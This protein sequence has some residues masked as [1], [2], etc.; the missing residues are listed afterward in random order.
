MFRGQ[1]FF[2]LEQKALAMPGSIQVS[3]KETPQGVRAPAIMAVLD[4]VITQGGAAVA[5]AGEQLHRIF[6]NIQLG[7]KILSTGQHFRILS[8]HVRGLQ[9]SQ[10]ADVPATN[11]GVFN[12]RV[13]VMIPF[14]D[15]RAAS[16]GDSAMRPELFAQKPLSIDFS[17][18][19]SLFPNVASITGT[20]TTYLVN[21]P[22]SP[23]VLPSDVEI[24]KLDWNGQH[25]VIEGS[26]LYT[27][28][29]IFNEDG[30]SIDDTQVSTVQLT[31]DGQVLSNLPVR[32]A[33]L[34]RYFD[35][36]NAEGGSLQVNSATAPVAGEALPDDPLV[37]NGAANT[38]SVPWIPLLT[39][40][41][42]YGLSRCLQ[43]NK[44][45]VID[46]TGSKTA[47]RVG[48]RSVP[49]RT[50]AQRQQANAQLGF[51][52]PSGSF[53]I[54]TADGSTSSSQR[55]AQYLPLQHKG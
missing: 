48:W 23:L 16:P 3:L 34:V 47:F 17:D 37:G 6:K 45:L 36:L 4:L 43:V 14:S 42:R 55:L 13:A 31:A 38:V 41:P 35:W 46:V 5:I 53:D 8:H 2:K 44:N 50:E 29:A 32:L 30:S 22:A 25:I 49:P 33:D 18:L 39:P 27:H 21:E 19:P 24:G 9:F 11:A 7:D 1:S 26:R 52:R 51:P 10:P 40:P 15:P 20:L 12:R 54:K 28:L